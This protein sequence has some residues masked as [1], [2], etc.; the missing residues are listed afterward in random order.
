MFEQLYMYVFFSLTHKPV[1]AGGCSSHW[2]CASSGF[3][4]SFHPA[5]PSDCSL[6][7][8]GSV[9]GQLHFLPCGDYLRSCAVGELSLSPTVS[10]SSPTL[11]CHLSINTCSKITAYSYTQ[12]A[13]ISEMKHPLTSSSSSLVI[14]SRRLQLLL[15]FCSSSS[16]ACISLLSC[17]SRE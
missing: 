13:E 1:S 14:F 5:D 17:S 9:C 11:F 10:E 3:S 2:R 7:S 15:Y 6:H 12:I 4:S 8:P 16:L